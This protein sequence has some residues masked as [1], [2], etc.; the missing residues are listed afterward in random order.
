[1]SKLADAIRKAKNTTCS[2]VVVAA[3]SSVRMGEDKLFMKLGTMPVLAR[4]LQALNACACVRE[5]VV[6]TREDRLEAV[7]RLCRDYGVLKATK[8][9]RGGKTR[10]ESALAGLMAID[11]KAKLVI[12]HDGARPLVTEEIV[13]AAVHG[14]ALYKCAAPAIPLT[15]TVKF[16]DG[17]VVTG[18]PPRKELAAI[19]TPQAFMT[20]LIKA[21]LTRAVRDG[22]VFTDDCAA[23]EAMG[24]SVRLTKGSEENIKITRPMDIPVAEAILRRREANV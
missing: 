20:E 7:A 9:V 6:V 14:A 22:A 1:M 23:V 16:T 17:Q 3:G 4:T 11:R 24:L 2:A 5:I 21:A 15:D 12:I 10:T 8:V 18:T 19:Q 13:W